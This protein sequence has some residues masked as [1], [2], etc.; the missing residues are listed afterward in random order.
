[1][2]R[3]NRIGVGS[4][5]GFVWVPRLWKELEV[6]SGATRSESE[7]ESRMIRDMVAKFVDNAMQTFGA[8]GVTREFPLRLMA[9][10]AR[11]CGVMEGPTEV[12]RM[13]IARKVIKGAA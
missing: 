12:R 3:R 5:L 1:M 8:M 13:N 6:T 9:Q 7:G 10:R 4:S 11:V 2:V